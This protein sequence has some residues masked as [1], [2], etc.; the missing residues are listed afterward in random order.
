MLPRA[1]DLL[2]DRPTVQALTKAYF[3]PFGLLFEPEDGGDIF[4]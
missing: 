4:M 1:P 3:H 2:C